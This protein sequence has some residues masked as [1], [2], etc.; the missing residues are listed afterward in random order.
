MIKQIEYVKHNLAKTDCMV[1]IFNEC[2]DISVRNTALWLLY[3]IQNVIV[4]LFMPV[5]LNAPYFILW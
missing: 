4:T 1:R 2:N 3:I 5:F